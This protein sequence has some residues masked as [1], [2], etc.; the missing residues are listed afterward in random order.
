MP[1]PAPMPVPS[2]SQSLS[3]SRAGD[4]MTCPLLYRFRAIDR[5]PEPPSKAATRGT[6]VHAVLEQLYDLPQGD[7]SLEAATGLVPTVWQQVL[8][9]DEQLG[10]LFSGDDGSLAA[11]WLDGTESLLSTYFTLEDPTRL[12][13]ADRELK[14]SVELAGG[15][16][17]RGYVDRLDVAPDGAMRVVDYKTGRSPAEAF[18]Q[19]AMFQMRFYALA[20]WRQRQ[21]VPRLLQLLY[22]G[23]GQVIQYEPDEDDLLAMERK[24]IALAAAIR[25]ATE[26]GDWRP[27]TSRLCDWCA[28]RALCPAWGGTPPP[29]PEKADPERGSGTS[30]GVQG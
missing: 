3:P 24:V 8:S 19:K 11:E 23:D 27:R 18:Q 6:V 10:D 1:S 7:R 14:L 25:R 20:L 22:L 17:L 4:F 29:L 13:P 30:E 12:Q 5:L 28:H 15:L 16:V 26:T 21:E 2:S 9:T